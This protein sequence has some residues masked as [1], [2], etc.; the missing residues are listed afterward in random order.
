MNRAFL[1][2]AAPA[3][4]VSLVFIT[5]GWG[6]RVSVPAGIAVLVLASI[7]LLIWRRR[8]SPQSGR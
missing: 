7:G 6:F 5:F 2:I 4:V 1:I 8:R 3:L